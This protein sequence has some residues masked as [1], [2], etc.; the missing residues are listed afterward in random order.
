M[1][2]PRE[3]YDYVT[4]LNG[5]QDLTN[6]QNSKKDN[7]THTTNTHILNVIKIFTYPVSI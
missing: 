4:T 6:I 2:S 7:N 1:S 3:I 5:C